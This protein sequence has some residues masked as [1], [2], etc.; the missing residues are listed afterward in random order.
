[1]NITI[2]PISGL[3]EA[4]Q[5]IES[6]HNGKLAS[7]ATLAQLTRWEHSPLR[8]IEFK[9]VMVGI[10]SF[11]SVHFVRHAAT[12]QRH[13]V[14]S[15]RDDRGGAGNDTVTR[16][17]PVKHTMRVNAQHLIDMAR[18]RLCHQASKETRSVML[19]IK[20]EI[21]VV[22]PDIANHLVPNC[23]YRGGVC[24]EPKPCGKYKIRDYRPWMWL[25]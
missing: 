8:E 17:S 4:R 7:K 21:G 14:M 6:T 15:N 24:V 23:V 22:W 20:E 16:N 11:V 5:A 13:Y 19:R 1:M 10:P 9:I 25:R 18:K 3:E 2:R 12:G